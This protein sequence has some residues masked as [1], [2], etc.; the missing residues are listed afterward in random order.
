MYTIQ[1]R[2]LKERIDLGFLTY[3][4]KGKSSFLMKGEEAI[5]SRQFLFSQNIISPHL[6]QTIWI[7]K[8]LLNFNFFLFL[9]YRNPVKA[10]PASKQASPVYQILF[11]YFILLVPFF[12]KNVL[13]VN[14]RSVS[15]V[16]F[17]HSK[18]AE[19]YYVFF[20]FTFLN[21]QKYKNMHPKSN[22]I[23]I[24]RKYHVIL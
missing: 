18:Y 20:L 3:H 21:T 2:R 23:I 8:Y 15:L 10:A 9:F 5:I 7:S 17:L 4:Y 16:Q 14:P 22:I 12:L 6:F 1:P 11:I 19:I 13:E 24:I